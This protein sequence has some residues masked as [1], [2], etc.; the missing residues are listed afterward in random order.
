LWGVVE[1]W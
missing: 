1:H